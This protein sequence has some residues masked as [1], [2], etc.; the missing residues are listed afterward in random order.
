MFNPQPC[1]LFITQ[2]PKRFFLKKNLYYQNTLAYR[3]KILF[4][5]IKVEEDYSGPSLP[6]DLSTKGE[7][8]TESKFKFKRWKFNQD[9]IFVKPKPKQRA[10]D[11]EF[12][13]NPLIFYSLSRKTT[14]YLSKGRLFSFF[15]IHLGYSFNFT[16]VYLCQSWGAC[17]RLAEV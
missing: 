7:S 8:K 1:Y 14:F 13:A 12:Y 6:D 16:V 3:L 10:R 5:C 2:A 9:N 15:Y 11:E 17:H 4:L